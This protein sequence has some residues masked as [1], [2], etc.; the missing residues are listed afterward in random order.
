MENQGQTFPVLQV[1]LFPNH[2]IIPSSILTLICPVNIFER[3]PRERR[4]LDPSPDSVPKKPTLRRSPL[5]KELQSP[6]KQG[7]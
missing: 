3:W 2:L 7:D 5:L 1:K 4:L 6:V